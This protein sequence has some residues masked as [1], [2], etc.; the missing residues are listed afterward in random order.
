[1]RALKGQAEWYVLRSKPHREFLLYDQLT[2]RNIECYF[3][4]IKV[5]PVNPRAA[6][7]KAFFPSYMFVKCNLDVIGINLFKWMPYSQGLVCFDGCPAIVPSNIIAGM[8]KKI[9]HIFENK[10]TL[11][12]G[13]KPGDSVIV[14][15]GPFEGYDGIFDTK[16][17]D[18]ERVRVLLKFLDHKR[19]LININIDQ[20]KIRKS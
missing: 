9:G 16:L 17:S 20:L 3:P 4:R 15:D 2:A 19:I 1:M 14:T 18:K 8:G 5:K 13:I 10:T 6:Q 11:K 12:N 7:V